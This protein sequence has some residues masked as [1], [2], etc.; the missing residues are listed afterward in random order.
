MRHQRGSIE[1]ILGVIL[2]A[3]VVSIGGLAL[4]T[5]KNALDRAQAAE[6]DAKVKGLALSDQRVEVARLQGAAEAMN[7]QLADRKSADIRKADIERMVQNALQTVYAKS[8][9]ARKWADTPVPADVL[10]SVRVN[11]AGV[12]GGGQDG[13]RAAAQ[14]VDGRNAGAAAAGGNDKRPATRFRAPDSLPPR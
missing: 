9:E 14:P 11:P 3:A 12:G 10:A 13:A 2:F 7:K 6:A 1:I 4:H 8:P 5:Y